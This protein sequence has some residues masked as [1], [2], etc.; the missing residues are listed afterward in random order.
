MEENS[1]LDISDDQVER[2]VINLFEEYVDPKNRNAKFYD[3]VLK[4]NQVKNLLEKITYT[5]RTVDK[6]VDY[7][8]DY[9][10][11]IITD[12]RNFIDALEKGKKISTLD[13]EK[14]EEQI[15]LTKEEL[16]G[17]KDD[18][19]KNGFLRWKSNKLEDIY[20]YLDNISKDIYLPV[21]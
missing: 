2:Q 6:I 8:N 1:E 18:D 15:R 10:Q 12:K 13:K 3:R 11:V 4:K 17:I 9:K 5:I 16:Y 14:I 7:Y 21:D 20:K 19:S